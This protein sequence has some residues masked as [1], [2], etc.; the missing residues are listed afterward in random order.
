MTGAGGGIGKSTALRFIREGAKV[1]ILDVRPGAAEAVVD[2]IAACGG[3]AIAFTGDAS[4]ETTVRQALDEASAEF[5]GLD[6]AAA[7]AGITI[8]S[9]TD[10]M[11][12]EIWDVTIRVNLTSVFLLAKYALPHLVTA[13]GGSFVTVGSVASLVAAGGSCAYDASKGAVLQLTRSI[14]AEYADRGI[15]ANCVCPGHIITDLASNSRAVTMVTPDSLR[16]PEARRIE[17]PMARPGEPEEI[18]SV[19][20]FL[21]SDEASYVTGVAI[22]VDGGHTAV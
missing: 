8:Y 3:K 13:G 1:A 17:R 15:R 6:I 4:D 7:C 22:P 9:E 16:R 5:G 20:A 14:A 11:S 18:A 2:E 21:C 19:I 12:L 10:S